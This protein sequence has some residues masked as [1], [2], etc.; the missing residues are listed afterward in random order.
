[1]PIIRL[2]ETAKNISIGKNLCDSAHS[3]AKD[4]IGVLANSI[5]RLRISVNKLLKRTCPNQ[6]PGEPD[7]E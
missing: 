7:K 5:D 2:S 4:E 3:E 1:G 6:K